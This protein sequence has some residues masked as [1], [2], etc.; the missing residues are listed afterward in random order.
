MEG[1]GA[2]ASVIAVIN[3]SAK[4][5]LL[6]FRY[7]TA[8]KNA[9]PDIE[10]LQ[11]EINRL[12]TTLEGLRQLLKSTNG[13]RLQTSQLLREGLSGCSS[14]LT[15][16]ETKLEKK[17]NP[18][19]TREIMG[20]IGIR[21]LKWPFESKEVDGIVKTL[22]RYRDAL[23]AGLTIDQT[24][25]ILDI[26]QKIDLSKFPIAKDAAF[27]SH[28]H[29]HDAR[30]HPKTRVR[31]C[32]DIMRWAEDPS[33]ECIFWLN[34]MAG[35]GKSTI[36]RTVSQ[37]FAD[38][39]E[40]GASFF[41]KRGERDRSN[42]A[43]FFGTIT[44]QLINKEP[45][46]ASYVRAAIEA[47]D[48]ISRKAM[49]E[50]F[51]KL[52]LKPLGN[53]NGDPDNPKR[54][55]IVVDALDECDRDDD[56]RVIIYLLSQ[57]KTLSLVRLR[58]FV[59]SRPELPIRLGFNDIKG[60]Y[61]DLVLHQIPKPVIEHDIAAYLEY[62]LARIKNDYNNSVGQNR[63]LPSDWPGQTIV[64]VLVDMAVPL[65]IFAATLCRFI[66]DRRCGDPEEQLTK[67]LTYKTRSPTSK[68]DATYLPI[69]DQLLVGLTDSEKQ[70]VID[71]FRI[72]IGSIVLLAEPLSTS[73]LARLLGIPESVVARA[74]D[75]LHSVLSIPSDANSPVRL[76]H[77]SFRDFL[78]NSETCEKNIFWIDEKGTHG[79]I[80]TKCLDLISGAKRLQA[81]ICELNFPGK[82]RA[83]INNTRIDDRLS[84]DIQY[85]CRY[86]VHHLEK[87]DS[88]I[89]DND[90][91]HMFLQKH[92]LHWLEA[93]SLIGKL[94][95]SV[96]LIGTLQTLLKPN[97][98]TKMFDFLHDAR[99]FI[100]KNH[101]IVEKAPLQLYPAIVFAP[102]TSLVSNT[103]QSLVPSWL[104]RL[105][106]VESTWSATLQTLEGH[107]G[108]VRAVAFSPDGKV[109]AS[110][111]NDGTVKLWD[112]STGAVLQ[113][114]EGHSGSVRA[115]AFSPDGKVLASASS[116]MTV[117]LWDASTGAV[118][119][120]LEGHWSW[121][122]AVAFSSDGKDGA[123]IQ[124]DRGVL[125]TTS[126]SP[127]DDL[128]QSSP[129]HGIFVEEQWVRWGIEDMLW[130]P[131]EYRRSCTAV[132]G[133]I[134]A[135]GH[136]TGRLLILEFAF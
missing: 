45:T 67:I 68:L 36:S 30:C 130:L 71:E 122:R 59:T 83:E 88:R 47:D 119:Q 120:T 98:S 17:L 24:A 104:R 28:A 108:W 116:D 131:P 84:T 117:K 14:Q 38:K 60:K 72:V 136:S 15:K 78:V 25:Q 100:L 31:L 19:G 89:C 62:E 12:K 80:A 74:L 106:K 53:L 43:L 92:F 93:L 109:L 124:T 69:L 65:F 29:E 7:S 91:V 115:V 21:A 87:S 18:G 107:S 97:A 10:R 73:S 77:L 103:F 58:I 134:V 5:A 128:S 63:W 6:C 121:I 35:T 133:S 41:F 85:S 125:H 96:G 79:M 95:E 82:L 51:E 56:V 11:E 113:T 32:E 34:G 44:S 27:D 55:V 57:A 33:G 126:P 26:S 2:T 76:L 37:S 101:W 105:S 132:Y 94:S 54:I 112:A 49:K 40:L 4:V 1:L 118:L 99:R 61:Q 114:L 135:L 129:L 127:S 22:E 3:L 13:P 123:F 20:R 110:A 42:A 50:Q 39:G 81:N 64:N 23:S 48:A 70:H 9:K 8:V 52:I 102:E 90:Q 86:W 16:L 111:S 75:L 46:L 66:K